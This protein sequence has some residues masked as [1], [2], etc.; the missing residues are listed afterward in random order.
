MSDAPRFAP[1]GQRFAWPVALLIAGL[2]MPWLVIFVALPPALQNFPINDDWA[3]AKAFRGWLEGRGLN[4]QGWASMPLWG[5]FAWAWPWTC[6]LG[7]SHV[8]L[9]ISTI[10]LS[11]LGLWAFY[12]LLYQRGMPRRI[13]ALTMLA[14]A[15]TP[16]MML[17][18]GSFMT[19]VPSLSFCLIALA[20][21]AR[22]IRD[23][24]LRILVW[25]TVPALLATTTRQNAIMAPLAALVLLG[26]DERCRQDP[27]WWL[28]VSLPAVV[29]IFC[30]QW[31]IQ[32]PDTVPRRPVL[33]GPGDMLL[34]AYVI[35]QFIGVFLW[36]LLALVRGRGAWWRWALCLG[37]MV[38]AQ[39]FFYGFRFSENNVGLFPYLDV[40]F[41]E[42]LQVQ[43][44]YVAG[45]QPPL[46]MSTALRATLTVLG[47]LGGAELLSRLIDFVRA[48]PGLD[49]LTAFTILQALLLFASKPL[50]DRYVFV[51]LPG[52]F[53]LVVA[54]GDHSRL[55]PALGSM[56]IV[57]S[58]LLSV[59]LTHDWLETNSARWRIATRATQHGLEAREI[60]GGREW[61]G[62]HSLAKARMRN[63]P[64]FAEL[65]RGV[66]YW[67]DQY[68]FPDLPG[69][70]AVS[71]RSEIYDL[72]QHLVPTRKIDSEAY[73]LWLSPHE[74][75]VFLLKYA[76]QP[77]TNPPRG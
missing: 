58:G 64:R 63:P 62:W 20:L 34:Y 2:I 51:L 55:R 35:V 11:W 29:C 69:T 44:Y 52:V 61:V 18:S 47:I 57:A 21:Y 33:L 59:A 40:W 19:D 12:D 7:L 13:A 46:Y 8:T 43:G 10:V 5:Q 73:W 50:Y 4:Y 17:L 14:L 49:I 38:A 24:D 53:A 65:P 15:W 27:L 77:E 56:L 45:A 9:R 30:H 22:A 42:A 41:P 72:E 39:G 68:E 28:I 6:A 32:R 16:Y 23:Y 60:D 26:R 54:A 66:N 67:R 36:P 1:H 37:I 31:F 71:F 25:A 48:R 75:E 76:P 74:R 70:Y 3:F